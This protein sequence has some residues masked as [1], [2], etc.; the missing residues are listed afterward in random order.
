MKHAALAALVIAT[1]CSLQTASAHCQIPCGIYGDEARFTEMLEHVTTIRKSINQINELNAAE[2][3]NINQLVRWV[4]NKEA[5]ADKLSDI[6]LTYF[7]AQRIKSGQPD[8]QDKLVVLHEIIVLSMKAKQG[9]DAS[10]ADGLEKAITKFK[11]LYFKG[12]KH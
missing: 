7:L 2:K 1:I 12:H 6:V 4:N 8:Y 9:T 10:T 5:H 11:G 3:K